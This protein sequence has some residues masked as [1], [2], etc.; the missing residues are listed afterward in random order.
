MERSDAW[1]PAGPSEAL[2]LDLGGL[3]DAVAE[4]VELR[5]AHVAACND[6]DLGD[7]RRVLRE[8][9]LDTD[10]EA[11]LADREGLADSAAL[12]PDHHALEHLHAFA[13]ALDDAHVH[14]EGVAGPEVGDVVAQVSA[15]D[16][17]GCVHRNPPARALRALPTAGVGHRRAWGQRPM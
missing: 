17:I 5:P 8:G 3:P 12:D 6:L 13:S 11:H 16:E 1:C 15:V 2:L 9:A 14:L 4:V 10:A 7:D